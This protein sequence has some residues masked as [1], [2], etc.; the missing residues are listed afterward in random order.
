MAGL[1]NTYKNIKDHNAKSGNSR[2]TWKYFDIMNEMF[3]KKPWAEPLLTLESGSSGI[4]SSDEEMKN[5]ASGGQKSNSPP[6]EK[7]LPTKRKRYNT[8]E[9]MIEQN[10]ATRLRMHEE[11]MSRQDKLLTILEKFIQQ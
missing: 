1:K 6:C 10:A 4:T 11:A 2:R 3:T 5:I 8:L 7:K 9:K